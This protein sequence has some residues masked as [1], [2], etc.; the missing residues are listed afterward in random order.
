VRLRSRVDEVPA[1]L[2]AV[3]GERAARPAAPVA[4]GRPLADR[5]RDLP[6]SDRDRLVLDVVTEH[7]AAVLGHSSREAVEPGR[8]FKDLGFDSLAAIE[9]RNQLGAATGLRLPATL[10]FD[11]PT[12]ADVA[13]YL[14][15]ALDPTPAD[16]AAALIEEVDRLE[17]ALTAAAAGGGHERITARLEALLR[18]WRQAR[19]DDDASTVTDLDTATDDELFAAL[20]RELGTAGGG[21]S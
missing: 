5:L 1:T 21:D 17:A 18:T 7:V 14:R 9:L 12:A 10:I 6:D 13:E 19:G 11:F 3:A 2:R 15:G 16:P 20:D 8:P 4:A